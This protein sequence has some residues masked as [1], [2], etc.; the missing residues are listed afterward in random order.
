MKNDRRMSRQR[1][2]C[3]KDSEAWQCSTWS[4][5][6]PGARG[7]GLRGPE[8]AASSPLSAW[9]RLCR[10]LLLQVCGHSAPHLLHTW[11]CH[12]PLQCH[13]P[14][15]PSFS[16]PWS[17]GWL[18]PSTPRTPTPAASGKGERGPLLHPKGAKPPAPYSNPWGS[19]F[20]ITSLS[21]ASPP[22]YFCVCYL[23]FLDGML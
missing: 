17:W 3:E 15:G 2:P 16:W 23:C 20:L 9:L 18:P 13:H 4:G 12:R 1:K 22:S 5:I 6:R 14:C 11:P 7:A 8:A 10:D 19:S 21:P